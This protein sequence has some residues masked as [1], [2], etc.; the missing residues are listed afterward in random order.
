MTDEE[1]RARL[2]RMASAQSDMSKSLAKVEERVEWFFE[3]QPGEAQSPVEQFVETTR[4]W[5]QAKFVA[6]L[7][8]YGLAAAAATTAAVMGWW[9]DLLDFARAAGGK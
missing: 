8:R 3:R 6:R 5:R 1:L 4:E 9:K 2:D 7:S